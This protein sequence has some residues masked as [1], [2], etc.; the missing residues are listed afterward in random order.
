MN[1]YNGAVQAAK[2]TG[3]QVNYVWSNWDPQ[4]MIQQF[5]EAAAT[6]PDGIAVMGH[7]GDQS[8]DPLIDDAES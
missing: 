8:F 2:D 5:T 4:K 1:V 7:P 6:K 3:A